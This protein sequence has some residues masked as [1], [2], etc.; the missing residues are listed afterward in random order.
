MPSY[1]WGRS[2][3]FNIPPENFQQ[4]INEL[5]TL[6]CS[7]EPDEDE[8]SECIE[9]AFLNWGWTAIAN[10]GDGVRRLDYDGDIYSDEPDYE[11]LS[12]IAPYVERGSIVE[13]GDD[14]GNRWCWYFDG[15]HATWHDGIVEYPTLPGTAI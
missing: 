11:V 4:V 5:D 14:S 13:M 10:A 12:N 2:K 9:D 3:N 7:G 8:R 1:I 6:L 15:R